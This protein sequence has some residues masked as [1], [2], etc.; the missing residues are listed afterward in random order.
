M[1][2]LLCIFLVVF[3]VLCLNG[4]M[5]LSSKD[6]LQSLLDYAA[7][8]PEKKVSLSGRKYRLQKPV[9]LD[10]RHNGLTIDGQG[11]I[12]TGAKIIKG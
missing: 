11:A 6:D 2:R 1:K 10:T 12:I 8:T 9:I 5:I 7:T 3:Y 4:E